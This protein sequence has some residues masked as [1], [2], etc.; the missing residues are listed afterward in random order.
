MY[1]RMI[2]LMT[3]LTA[4]LPLP[5][6]A[7][8]QPFRARISG[9]GGDG[10]CT[11]EV[12][13]DGVAEVTIRGDQGYLQTISG[14]PARWRRL[15]CNQPMPGNPAD[16]RFRGVDGRGSQNLVRDP[17]S[18]RGA[19]VIRIDDPKGGSDGYTG[20][21]TWRGMGS[22]PGGGAPPYGGGGGGGRPPYGGGGGY[23]G[24]GNYA[25]PRVRVDT[26]GRGNYS[27]RNRSGGITRGGVDTTGQPRVMLS[28]E[29]NLRVTFWGDITRQNGDREFTMRITGSDQGNASGTATFRLNRDQNEVEYI[30]LNGKMNGGSFNGNFSR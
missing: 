15:D 13:V 18:N 3:A 14:N 25:P 1:T 16:F 19:A 29:R 12:E 22:Y 21:V 23:P 6:L 27:A 20:D 4:A 11:F 24:G 10:K 17:N 30:N 2:A 26:S 28:D 8:G 7:Q 5:A 9:G